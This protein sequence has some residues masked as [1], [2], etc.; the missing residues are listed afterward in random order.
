MDLSFCIPQFISIT[1]VIISY[2][3]MRRQVKHEREFSEA[4]AK[5]VQTLW[6]LKKQE[7]LQPKNSNGSNIRIL[8]RLLDGYGNGLR[9]MNMMSRSSNTYSVFPSF[10]IALILMT[11]PFLARYNMQ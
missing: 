8:Q 1:A 6:K 4:L 10:K 2:V 11:N 7:L 9:N 3:D 5:H